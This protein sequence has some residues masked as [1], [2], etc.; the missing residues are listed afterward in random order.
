LDIFCFDTIRAACRAFR[1]QR[2]GTRKA[3]FNMK[4]LWITLFALYTAVFFCVCVPAAGAEEANTEVWSI[5]A[6][7][8]D[9]NG[10]PYFGA[11]PT[12][13]Y[14]E[15]GLQVTPATAKGSYTIQTDH[16]YY[17]D[18]GIYLE[19]TVDNPDT[20]G[21]LFFH[22]WDQN[23]VLVNNY[24]CGSGW[25]CLIQLDKPETK[26]MISALVQG[27]DGDDL[28]DAS[29]LGSMKTEVP[30]NADG[31]ATYS[32]ELKNDILRINGSVVAGMDEV[33]AYLRQIRPDGSV[34]FGVSVV[35]G[36]KSEPIPIT[37]T[38]FGTS[39]ETAF[40]PGTSGQ[41]PETGEI[42]TGITVPDPDV[43]DPAEDGS[44]SLSPETTPSG[45]PVPTPDVTGPAGGSDGTVQEGTESREPGKETEDDFDSPF[46]E[47]EPE[48]K[49]TIQN[50]K[51]DKFMDK[52]E[53]ISAGCGSALGAGSLGIASLL[54]A[55]C[56]YARKRD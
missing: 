32:L 19:I 16:A 29:I 25:E 28:G 21:V 27:S 5:Y 3:D 23:G 39:K 48:T 37:V 22:I 26:F 35:T 18:K 33:L 7:E 45:E 54:A 47:T 9:A 41:L 20:I 12:Y 8:E 2:T 55:A 50:D 34:Y 31:T 51:I 24:N 30:V 42:S 17:M 13:A 14:T 43:T 38:R 11:P 52:M 40:V 56:F 46:E 1:H 53:Q 6:L 44:S 36:D 10:V 15:R 49:K 4:R